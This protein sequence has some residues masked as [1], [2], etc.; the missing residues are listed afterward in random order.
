[1]R[2]LRLLIT[3]SLITTVES[4][5][6][7]FFHYNSVFYIVFLLLVVI[8][9]WAG[10]L[11]ERLSRIWGFAFMLPKFSSFS[12]SQKWLRLLANQLPIGIGS[13][14]ILRSF[15]DRN[16]SLIGAWARIHVL[17]LR[18]FAIRHFGLKD[19]IFTSWI[20]LLLAHFFKIIDSWTRIILPAHVVVSHIML[21]KKLSL[22]FTLSEVMNR[23]GIL[24]IIV[25]W[26]VPSWAYKIK[27]SSSVGSSS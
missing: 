2:S 12:F 22:D 10:Y 24:N 4:S 15:F 26:I 25:F 6:D 16:N 9:A 17:I 1:M 19:L 20:E 11:W 23:I 8:L 18:I 5:L 7:S 21:L 14:M 27:T 3:G 13:L